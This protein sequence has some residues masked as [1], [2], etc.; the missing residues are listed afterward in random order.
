MSYEVAIALFGGDKTTL[1]KS[2]TISL[3]NAATNWY[4]RLLLR[5]IASWAQPKEKFLINFYGFQAYVS[6]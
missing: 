3:E 6:T 1:I 2:F 4:A 5:S